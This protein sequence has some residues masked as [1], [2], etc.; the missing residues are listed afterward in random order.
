MKRKLIALSALLFFAVSIFLA[1]AKVQLA[2]AAPCK[3]CETWGQLKTC[4]LSGDR[5]HPCCDCGKGVNDIE[6][7][8]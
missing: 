4:G 8:F 6:K 3:P 5:R 1:A 2:S 7:D